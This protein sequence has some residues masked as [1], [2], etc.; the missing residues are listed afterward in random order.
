M[1]ARARIPIDFGHTL[2][3]TLGK[4]LPLSIGSAKAQICARKEIALAEIDKT[5]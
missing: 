2:T 4:A 1:R 5:V 3:H